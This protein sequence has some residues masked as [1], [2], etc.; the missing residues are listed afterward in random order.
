M[1]KKLYNYKENPPENAW[2]NIANA[3]SN[4]PKNNINKYYWAI[5]ALL[6][7]GISTLVFTEVSTKKIAEKHN[8]IYTEKTFQKNKNIK[9]TN[10]FSSTNSKNKE[11]NSSENSIEIQEEITQNNLPSIENKNIRNNKNKNEIIA[12]A[13]NLFENQ[14]SKSAQKIIN[15]KP[16]NKTDLANI[17]AEN[18]TFY[19]NTLVENELVE[20]MLFNKNL[21]TLNPK[22]AQ[23]FEDL[24]DLISTEN[25]S[26]SMENTMKNWQVQT[27]FSPIIVKSA[28]HESSLIDELKEYHNKFENNS[29]FGAAISYKIN[30]DWILKS[31]IE[32][33]NI[34][35]TTDNVSIAPIILLES[36]QSN[37][38]Y[39]DQF[40]I[41][42]YGENS[43]SLIEFDGR[44]I[45]DKG[46]VSQ[47]IAYAGIPVQVGYRIF[48]ERKINLYGIAGIS[49]YFLAKNKIQF[50][51]ETYSSNLG[52]ANNLN[53]VV[54]G[55]QLGF[56]FQY[57]LNQNWNINIQPQMKY[58]FNTTNSDIKT[59]PVIIGINAG[60]SYDF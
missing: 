44:L 38:T 47:E 59:Q 12:N 11:N 6:F 17:V 46:K 26:I 1:R 54:F 35:Q 8:K 45:K 57:N 36:N 50:Q 19:E 27:Y 16:K 42:P 20:T 9:K 40:I 55:S 7:M 5:F 24:S 28:Q 43:N 39:S 3:L 56:D 34:S 37:I 41:Q 4:K 49:S 33:F 51:N 15:Q 31:G 21:I 32:Y 18:E 60:I 30:N 52:E 58:L 29:L 10:T 25:F 53:N 48:G 22:N 14:N 23:S 13:N 2:Q